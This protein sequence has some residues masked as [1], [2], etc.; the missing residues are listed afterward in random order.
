MGEVSTDAADLS[1]VAQS[2]VGKECCG[3]S[4]PGWHDDVIEQARPVH[5]SHVSLLMCEINSQPYKTF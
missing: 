1:A 5:C 3:G 4:E 2:Q